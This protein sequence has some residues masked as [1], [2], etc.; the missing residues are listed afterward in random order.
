[1][2]EW[3]DKA[4]LV[5]RTAFCDRWDT[6]AHTARVVARLHEDDDEGRAAAWLHDVLED[7]PVT[8]SDLHDM[9]FPDVIAAAVEALTR[10]EDETY[11]QYVTRLFLAPGEIGVLA[12]RVKLADASENLE[13]CKQAAGVPKWARLAEK[14]YRPLVQ[15][16][17][18]SF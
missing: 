18:A 13:R 2:G 11:D 17:E 12:R 15:K 7:T 16:L 3:A 9:G 4:E 1:M 6:L 5:A 8:L 14:R 10:R